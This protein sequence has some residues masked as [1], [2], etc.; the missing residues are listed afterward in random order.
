MIAVPQAAA[1]ILAG[2]A[3]GFLVTKFGQGTRTRDAA[4]AGLCV[5][6]LALGITFA[7]VGASLASLIVPMLATGAAALGGALGARGRSR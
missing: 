6:L 2:M 5:G 3:G 7:Q 4:F 1:L